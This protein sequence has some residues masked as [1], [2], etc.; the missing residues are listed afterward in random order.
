MQGYERE[1]LILAL[2]L[3]AVGIPIGWV[4]ARWDLNHAKLGNRPNRLGLNE[5]KYSEIFYDVGLSYVFT[6]LLSLMV[7]GLSHS[8]SPKELQEV[9]GRAV[10]TSP[11]YW[12]ILAGACLTVLVS[13]LVSCLGARK[14]GLRIV[15]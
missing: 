1:M 7:W 6:C 13:C 10:T 5:I 8:G 15:W 9:A 11:V 12:G 14:H 3:G 2:F 4:G